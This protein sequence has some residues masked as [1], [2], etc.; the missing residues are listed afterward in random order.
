MRRARIKVQAT[1]PVRRKAVQPATSA[2]SEKPP[3][4]SDSVPEVEKTIPVKDVKLEKIENARE[5]KTENLTESSEKLQ[6]EPGISSSEPKIIFTNETENKAQENKSENVEE[7]IA[8]CHALIKKEIIAD[9]HQQREIVKVTEKLVDS[10]VNEES[11]SVDNQKDSSLKSKEIDSF[12]EMAADS[13][14]NKEINNTEVSKETNLETEVKNVEISKQV[15]V[16]KDSKDGDPSAKKQTEKE[17]PETFSPHVEANPTKHP[18]SR[19]CFMRPVPRL[20]SGGRVRRNSVQGSGAS[21]SESEDDSRKS[22]ISP[23]VRSDS[24]CSVQSNKDGS[25]TFHGVSKLKFGQKRRLTVSESA[26]KLAEARRE[27]MLK[28]ENKPPDRNTLTMYD[29]IY[30][31]PISNPMSGTNSP[32][33]HPRK[34]SVCSVAPEEIKEKEEVAEDEPTA[35][36][37]PRVKVGPNGELILDQTSLII[38]RTEKEKNRSGPIVLDENNSG[39]FYKRRQKSKEWSKWDTLRFYRALSNIGTD[40]LLMQSFFPKRTRQELKLKFKKEERTNKELVEKALK[41]QVF[42]M[43]VLKEEMAT[44][45]ENERK[46]IEISKSKAD[47]V[48]KQLKTKRPAKCRFV[49]G[50]IEEIDESY[51]EDVDGDLSSGES[52]DGNSRKKSKKSSRRKRK[53]PISS[54]V[55]E[56]EEAAE[57]TSGTED[58]EIYHVKPT[59]S[60]RLPKRRKLQAPK[61]FDD[62]SSD[63]EEE[64]SQ[65]QDEI[66]AASTEKPIRY[67]PEPQEI[68]A[69]IPNARDIESGSLVI[70]TRESPGEPGKTVMQVFMVSKNYDANDPNSQ[71]NM[72]PV[73]LS[74][75]LLATVNS[76][77]SETEPVRIKPEVLHS[78]E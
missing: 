23:R 13:S 11:T 9:D 16:L 8:E 15:E 24:I 57:S 59:R 40:F 65:P 20:D 68:I 27:F 71:Q 35:M 56:E 52:R 63:L 5:N 70:L 54:E 38:E 33:A 61:A 74:P 22:S 36:P 64:E 58:T 55:E 37:V 50:S 10:V 77:I 25:S 39:G 44:F 41:C 4:A 67:D 1:V 32:N 46:E 62:D 66:S 26:R 45:E 6:E 60:G 18:Q 42:D 7:D 51:E 30:Y 28:H 48:K 17:V 43:E 34:M 47:V 14:A 3:P 72:T 53:V 78:K 19:S 2:D 31:N 75:E 21:A 29:L 12:T 73:S 49:V 76:K 69:N